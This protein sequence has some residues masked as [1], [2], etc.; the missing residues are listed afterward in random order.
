MYFLLLFWVRLLFKYNE[1]FS[2]FFCLKIMLMYIILSFR[3]F[4]FCSFLNDLKKIKQN[5]QSTKPVN[6]AK[7]RQFKRDYNF[8]FLYIIINNKNIYGSV[9]FFIEILI[10]SNLYIHEITQVIK[11]NYKM[12]KQTFNINL[13]EK[14]ALPSRF[15]STIESDANAYRYSQVKSIIWCY[16]ISAA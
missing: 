8:M 12:C 5:N 10:Y 3:S 1:T 13:I 16:W 6:R 14:I 4:L 9:K 15:R 2:V 11:S 7:L